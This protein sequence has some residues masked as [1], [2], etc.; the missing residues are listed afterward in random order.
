[1]ASLSP[2]SQSKQWL[3]GLALEV[4]AD[5][6]RVG[7]ERRADVDHRIEIVVLDVD[8]FERVACRIAVL[9]DDERDL[10]VLE[11][12]LVGG[13]HG[14]D[15]VRQRRHPR[16]VLLG[17]VGTRDDG[18]H[19]RVS[20]GGGLVDA[21]DACM[22]E[23][24]SQDREV[25]H[26]RELHVVAV[27]A[28]SSNEPGILLAEH[29]TEADGL[30]IVEVVVRRRYGVGVD[31]VVGDGHDALPVGLSVTA[32]SRSLAAAHWIERTMVA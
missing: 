31:V 13:E 9:G 27:L 1:M 11:A 21:D 2:V 5:D 12:H 3:F 22:C 14:L 19:L 28:H 20:F 23:R 6:R 15:V 8:Q 18:N 29:A 24:R 25:Q 10:L 30:V 17:Q 32:C 7:F 16:Q 26:A 4:V